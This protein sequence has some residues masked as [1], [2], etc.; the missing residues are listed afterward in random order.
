M[1]TTIVED[2]D[3]PLD[4]AQALVGGTVEAVSHLPNLFTPERAVLLVHE[5]ARLLRELPTINAFAT[6]LAGRVVFGNAVLL[7]GEKA[8]AGWA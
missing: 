5:D 8:L 4:R 1:I 7:I 6:T 2:E 3:L